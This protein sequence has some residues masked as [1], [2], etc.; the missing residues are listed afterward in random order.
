MVD[1]IVSAAGIMQTG[2]YITFFFE[3]ACRQRVTKAEMSVP[4][5]LTQDREIDPSEV[6][7]GIAHE[8]TLYLPIPMYFHSPV[9]ADCAVVPGDSDLG[10]AVSSFFHLRGLLC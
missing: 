10:G 8:P 9:T 1:P 6:E 7:K 4:E 2:I 5:N 3:E